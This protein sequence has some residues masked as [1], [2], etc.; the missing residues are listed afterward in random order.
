MVGTVSTSC[1]AE[2]AERQRSP[3]LHRIGHG[4][5]AMLPEHVVAERLRRCRGQRMVRR[6][7]VDEGHLA[8][9]L[10]PHARVKC[11]APARRPSARSACPEVSASSVPESDSSRSRKRVGGRSAKNASASSITVAHAIDGVDRDRQ[12]RLPARWRRA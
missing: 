7:R 1:P 3:A 10:A 5:G 8:Q 6:H 11:R 9:R 12:L 2:Q 4:D